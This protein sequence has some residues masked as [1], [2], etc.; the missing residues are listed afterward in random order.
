MRLSPQPVAIFLLVVCLVA[1]AQT[2]HETVRRVVL[3]NPG[4]IHCVSTDCYQLW[5]D[6]APQPGDIYPLRVVVSLL[7]KHCPAGVSAIYDKSVAFEDLQAALEARYGKGEPEHWTK[8][9]LMVWHVDAGNFSIML[10]TA[11]KRISK[12]RRLDLG[13][14]ELFLPIHASLQ[15]AI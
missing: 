7:G 10:D 13:A 6:H 8:A 11:D 4:L 14:K 3:P 12:V 2:E 15:R 9:A 5:L 1:H